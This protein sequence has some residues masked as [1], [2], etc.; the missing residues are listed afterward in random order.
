MGTTFE[1]S[2]VHDEDDAI[3]VQAASYQEAL[4]E[5]TIIFLQR[6]E[7]QPTYDM[8]LAPN[9]CQEVSEGVYRFPF[10]KRPKWASDHL[11]G[12]TRT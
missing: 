4:S 3:I 5:A 6:Q 12:N 9:K 10:T 11:K 8:I 2:S 1:N 7:A